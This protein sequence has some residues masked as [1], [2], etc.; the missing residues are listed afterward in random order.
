MLTTK[1]GRRAVGQT[2]T[3]APPM[4]HRRT[5]LPLILTRRSPSYAASGNG[6]TAS[7]P[8]ERSH[9][10][11]ARICTSA[12]LLGLAPSNGISFAAGLPG[13]DTFTAAYSREARE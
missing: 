8:D 1:G 2:L 9:M 10:G 3:A 4:S 11:K 6:V 5:G 13:A 7:R 12:A